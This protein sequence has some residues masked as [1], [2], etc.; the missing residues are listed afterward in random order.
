M[1]DELPL[2]LAHQLP[3]DKKL[4]ADED[5]PHLQVTAWGAKLASDKNLILI[6]L[7]DVDA[8]K[9]TIPYAISIPAA[10]QLS[11]ALGKVVDDYLNVSPETE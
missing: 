3:L 4:L 7:Q 1:T 8:R 9:P 2:T 6:F 10:K 11:D 5:P